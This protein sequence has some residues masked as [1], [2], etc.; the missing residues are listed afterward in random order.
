M[1][2]W[3]LAIPKSLSP[4]A[5]QDREYLARHIE[6]AIREFEPRLSGVQ[7]LVLEAQGEFRYEIV[8]RRVDPDDQTLALRVLTPRRGGGLGADIVVLGYAGDDAQ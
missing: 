8:A 4:A 1:L 5:Q 6:D 3:G 2:N 7:V